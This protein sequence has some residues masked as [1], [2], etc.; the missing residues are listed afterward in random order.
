MI[1]KVASSWKLRHRSTLALYFL[2]ALSLCSSAFAS[3]D[4]ACVQGCIQRPDLN[5]SLNLLFLGEHTQEVQIRWETESPPPDQ[6]TIF[7]YEGNPEQTDS[8]AKRTRVELSPNGETFSFHRNISK[9][10]LGR[11]TYIAVLVDEGEEERILDWRT[12]RIQYANNASEEPT[13]IGANSVA[14]I[15]QYLQVQ[16]G[17]GNLPKHVGGDEHA[18]WTLPGGAVTNLDLDGEH[19][20][21][22]GLSIAVSSTWK[23]DDDW[24]SRLT[25]LLPTISGHFVDFGDLK[26]YQTPDRTLNLP[27]TEVIIGHYYGAITFFTNASH[28]KI[29][30]SDIGRSGNRKYLAHE[31]SAEIRQPQHPRLWSS[32][33]RREYSADSRLLK[34]L[35]DQYDEAGNVPGLSHLNSSTGDGGSVIYRAGFDINIRPWLANGSQDFVAGLVGIDVVGVRTGFGDIRIRDDGQGK[36]LCQIV[37]CDSSTR[38]GLN[39]D[40]RGYRLESPTAIATTQSGALTL[41]GEIPSAS[42]DPLQ[43]DL[44]DLP[45]SATF[46]LAAQ[47]R[48]GALLEKGGFVLNRKI[49]ELIPINSYAQ[50]VVKYTVAMIPEARQ[51]VVV[52]T[53]QNLPSPDQFDTSAIVT[54][55]K[56]IWGAIQRLFGTPLL[57]LIG[58]VLVFGLALLFPG[59]RSVVNALL[60]LVATALNWLNRLLKPGQKGPPPPTQPD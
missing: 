9:E 4:V 49:V 30:A 41:L 34:L 43:T 50:F 54:P 27:D 26:I 31:T 39:E 22:P 13:T 32:Y 52:S 38:L 56:S 53:E 23:I 45:T 40:P 35:Q 29:G 20:G 58:G 5:R 16:S 24:Q 18:W 21:V 55:G 6:S 33:S 25:D 42:R 2:S 57:L 8:L 51:A 36:G 37:S 14:V 48:A 47:L 28:A 12:F 17:H 44:P 59:V 15:P 10:Q 3:F 7:L 1:L 11:G 60:Q 19:T 46:A